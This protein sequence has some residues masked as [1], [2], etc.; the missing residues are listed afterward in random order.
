MT[1][2]TENETNLL[3][4]QGGQASPLCAEKLVAVG[5]VLAALA[6]SS[7]CIV[8]LALFG[9]GISG[10]WIANLTR[11]AQ[12]LLSGNDFSRYFGSECELL[13]TPYASF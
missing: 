8:P 6:A 7:C 3:R 12:R 1:G 2:Q 13:H 4:A 11:L 5:G 9:L 10:A